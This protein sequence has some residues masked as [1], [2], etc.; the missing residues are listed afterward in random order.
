MV[1]PG[2]PSCC[3]ASSPTPD[4]ARF[5]HRMVR[6][7]PLPPSRSL[8]GPPETEAATVMLAGAGHAQSQTRIVQGIQEAGHV[9]I[10]H[11]QTGWRSTAKGRLGDVEKVMQSSL[12]QAET[13]LMG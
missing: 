7:A 6:L 13:A 5:R 3:R 9:V 12:V 2:D 4:R 11:P 8:Q 10:P 1:T